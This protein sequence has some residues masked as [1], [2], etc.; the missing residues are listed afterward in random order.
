[1]RDRV[2]ALHR[3]RSVQI[4]RA[5]F[6]VDDDWGA[7][8]NGPLGPADLADEVGRSRV[9][10]AEAKRALA[11]V[12]G[13]MVGL[14]VALTDVLALVYPP[15]DTHPWARRPA[16]PE[17]DRRRVREGRAA[18]R[19]W[20]DGA[21]L[22]FSTFGGDVGGGGGGSRGSRHDSVILYTNLLYMYYQ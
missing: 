11:G 5:H 10:A 19:R 3:R 9:Y 22:L 2:L 1:M 16:R 14:C 15:D 17:D 21:T 8:S 4:T 18:L 6:D 12:T 20:Y 7:P 13:R